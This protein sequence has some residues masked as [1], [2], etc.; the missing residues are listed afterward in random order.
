MTQVVGLINDETAYREM[1]R[2]GRSARTTTSPS[3]LRRLDFRKC[4]TEHAPIIIDGA[5]LEQ[6]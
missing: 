3:R 4:R 5:V 6:V 1:V 2:P